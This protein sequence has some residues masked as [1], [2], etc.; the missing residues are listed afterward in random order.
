MCSSMCMSRMSVED[1]GQVLGAGSLPPLWVQAVRIVWWALLPTERLAGP[2]AESQT[3]LSL[4]MLYFPLIRLKL[5]V[6]HIPFLLSLA[7]FIVPAQNIPD[8]SVL[9][10]PCHLGGSKMGRQWCS[11]ELKF[12]TVRELL[13]VHGFSL[14]PDTN[15]SP[16][17]SPWVSIRLRVSSRTWKRHREKRLK[18]LTTSAPTTLAYPCACDCRWLASHSCHLDPRS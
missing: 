1:R 15:V 18:I 4:R 3:L 5:T 17:S 7:C 16:L 2:L 11:L 6:C 14:F 8:C 9:A 13:L 12:M 10:L